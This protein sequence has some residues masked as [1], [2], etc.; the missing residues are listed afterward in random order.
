MIKYFKKIFQK[1][2]T[3][4]SFYQLLGAQEGL[5][6]LVENFYQTMQNDPL[7]KECLE[8]HK[9]EDNKVSKQSKTKLIWFLSGWLGGPN[10]FVENIGHPRMR[11]RHAHVRISEKERD[12][13]L[14]CMETA[15]QKHSIRLKD[16]PYTSLMRSFMALAYRIQNSN[17]HDNKN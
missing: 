12:Q 4:Q 6:E 14:Y 9:L 13:W 8:L 11:M 3:E 15:L 2:K 17:N 10:L 1:N 5:K 16:K 7:A